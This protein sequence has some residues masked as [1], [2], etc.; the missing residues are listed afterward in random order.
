MQ[1]K[2]LAR[3]RFLSQPLFSHADQT[4]TKVSLF[5]FTSQRLSISRFID[6]SLLK[7]TIYIFP[8]PRLGDASALR[9]TAA[10]E[11]LAAKQ[12][13]CDAAAQLAR[14]GADPSP[15]ARATLADAGRYFFSS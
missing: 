7:I 15:D 12:H 11:A 1:K 14:A 4:L 8:F 2:A 9:A 6:F 3:Y 5:I 13:F 10:R